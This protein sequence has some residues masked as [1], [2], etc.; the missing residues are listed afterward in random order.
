M[1][2]SSLWLYVGPKSSFLSNRQIWDAIAD[3]GKTLEVHIF[4]NIENSY[5]FKKYRSAEGLQF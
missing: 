1:C 3:V 5:I 4:N 2:P